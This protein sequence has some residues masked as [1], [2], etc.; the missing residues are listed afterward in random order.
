MF[1]ETGNKK[2]NMTSIQNHIDRMND[3]T[4]RLQLAYNQYT[5]SKE[6]S[7]GAVV[8]TIPNDDK[9]VYSREQALQQFKDSR[10]RAELLVKVM[11]KQAISPKQHAFLLLDPE[12]KSDP[13]VSDYSLIKQNNQCIWCCLFYL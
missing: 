2:N 7:E 9:V 11:N 5:T 10:Q 13:A 8:L 12:I 1:I 3:M 6:E 4:S